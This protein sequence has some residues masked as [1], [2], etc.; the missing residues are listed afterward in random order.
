M[1]M[2]MFQEAQSPVRLTARYVYAK[3]FE[4]QSDAPPAAL[5]SLQSHLDQ[6]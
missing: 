1:I 4:M 5:Q 2:C 3:L 6:N